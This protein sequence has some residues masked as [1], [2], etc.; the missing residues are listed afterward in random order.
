MIVNAGTYG[1]IVV[2]G[3]QPERATAVI[4][5]GGGTLQR[6]DFLSAL[7]MPRLRFDEL[8]RIRF[9]LH[10]RLGSVTPPRTSPASTT[11]TELTKRATTPTLGRV[12]SIFVQ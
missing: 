4:R 2:V 5:D 3:I 11:S 8:F 7:T 10:R 9:R 1:A 6:Y 12:Q